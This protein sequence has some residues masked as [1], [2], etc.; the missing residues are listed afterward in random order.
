VS[1]PYLPASEN[2]ILEAPGYPVIPHQQLDQLPTGAWP[3][4]DKNSA[5]ANRAGLLAFRRGDSNLLIW[6]F[7]IAIPSQ[8]S[9]NRGERGVWVGQRLLSSCRVHSGQTVKA[10]TQY[11]RL[12]HGDLYEALRR[13]QH[14][15]DEA[16]VRRIGT[17]P[18]W[19]KDA[20]IYEAQIGPNRW[21]A[22]PYDPYPDIADLTSDLPRIAALGFNI[23]ELMPHQVYPDYSVHDYLDI[24]TQYAREKD[25]RKMITR[26][27]ELGLKVL[28]DV[29]MHG[30]IDK[31][32]PKIVGRFDVHPYITA[33]P[34]WFSYNEDGSMA[35]TYTWAFDHASPS[36][37]DFIVRV[38]E[39]YVRRLDVD[40][41]REDA[42]TWN[43]FPNWAKDLPRLGYESFFA[44]VPMFEKVRRRLLSVKPELLFYTETQGPLYDS[45]FDLSYNYDEQPF[46]QALLSLLSKRGYVA[47]RPL[48]RK[49]T[50]R[51]M[52]QWLDM[53]RLAFPAGWRKVHHVDSHDSYTWGGLGMF[54]KE[55][56]G[57]EGARLLFAFCAFLDGGIMNYAG[58][59]K[60]SEEF[61]RKVLAVR[62]STPALREGMCDY[63]AVR[64]A[65]DRVLAPLRRLGSD[66][67]LPVLSF[68]AEPIRTALPLDA[69]RLRPQGAYTLTEVFSGTERVGK[70]KDL[71]RLDIE[72]SP[73]AVQVWTARQEKTP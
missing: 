15:W 70:G 32:T 16:G 50:A 17:T 42:L 65:S 46:Y 35:K 52:A 67:A 44:S 61:Y 4:L 69:L 54:R 2:G 30:V 55:A 51:E 21:A 13:F 19:G 22:R 73:Y 41:F 11:L 8:M 63:L 57:V 48:P 58:A 47:G 37:Q 49:I 1:T 23:V 28:L 66:W 9:V 12:E 62:E 7:D 53:R 14:S 31:R 36:F 10:G 33:H 59:E 26:A 56:F 25:L 40:G 68:S 20:R 34:D 24:D 38:H 72:L 71:S 27:H 3:Q 5:P 64:P 60:G 43:S 45:C 18:A 6:G 29:V 39:E